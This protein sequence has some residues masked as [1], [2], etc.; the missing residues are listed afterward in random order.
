MWV[1]RPP[2]FCDRQSVRGP[3]ALLT[4]SRLAVYSL[5]V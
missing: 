1:E 4:Q 2:C 5:P 3:Y